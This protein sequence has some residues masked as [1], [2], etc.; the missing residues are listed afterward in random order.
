[1][2][3]PEHEKRLAEELR[4]RPERPPV[5]RLSRRV[6]IAL[7]GVSAAAI[8]G[9][10]VFAL[11]QRGRS[12]PA[13][14]LYNTEAKTTADGLAALPPDYTGLPKNVPKLG[15]PLPGDL[16]RPI[17]AAQGQLPQ[18]TVD[19]EQQRLGQERE[20]ARIAKLF[21][22]T[23]AHERPAAAPITPA[24]PASA[25]ASTSPGVEFGEAPPIDPGA[26]Q[27]MQD[28]KLAFI[29][30]P[31]HR[32]TVSSDRLAQPASR[33]VL[34]AGA[35]IPAA[36]VTGIRSDL[37]GQITAQVTENIYD[38]PTGRFL[39]IPQGAKLI[40]VY[41][42]Q[43]AFGQSRVLL[44]WNRLV[45]PDGQ[46]IALERQPGADAAGYSGLEDEVDHHWLRLAGAAALSTILGVGT[47]LGTAGEESALIQA[48][49][50]GGAQSLN[51]TGQQIVGRNLNIQPT[52]TIRPG[53]PVRVIVTRDLV[54]A[55]YGAPSAIQTTGLDP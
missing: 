2:S 11:Q 49:R 29:S 31:A 41:D 51:Q 33:Y 28:R 19:P 55:P 36:L 46:S 23:N 54:L 6:L 12:G 22:S 15:P 35:V 21:A 52:L 18:T 39:L 47:Q 16:G 20:A 30:A 4:L 42:S 45:R 38:S 44:V 40:G 14:E 25:N 5:T 53:F 48:L 26:I 8:L 13:P 50:R 32:H 7:S 34:Q 27:N 1:M 10:T 24:S 17:L 43:I 37:P 3:A 9:L